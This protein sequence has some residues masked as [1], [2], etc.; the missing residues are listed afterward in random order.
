MWKKSETIGDIQKE[1]EETCAERK[2][3]EERVNAFE[4]LVGMILIV[5]IVLIGFGG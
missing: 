1:I 4:F 5:A 2:I 3:S